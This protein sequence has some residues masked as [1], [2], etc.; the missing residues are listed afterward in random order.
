[1]KPIEFR[2]IFRTSTICGIETRQIEMTLICESQK[3]ATGCWL[4]FPER[5]QN[6]SQATTIFIHDCCSSDSRLNALWLINYCLLMLTLLNLCAH[7]HWTTLSLLVLIVPTFL[8]WIGFR[9]RGCQLL[10]RR[11]LSK[12]SP[13]LPNRYSAN[14]VWCIEKEQILLSREPRIFSEF[15]EN[16]C[17]W[18]A[19]IL[20]LNIRTLLY[21]WIS[22][23]VMSSL[24][25][26]ICT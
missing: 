21:C 17:S 6:I 10:L 14:W 1:M 16:F 15:A 24:W 8:E 26:W 23:I 19:W 25:L 9:H 22:P 13:N 18:L 2:Q 4:A 12:D 7:C 3:S 20:R 11:F 5:W